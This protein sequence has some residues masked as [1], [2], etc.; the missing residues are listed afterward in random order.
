MHKQLCRIQTQHVLYLY[1][2][3]LF[4]HGK[5][6]STLGKKSSGWLLMPYS[7]KSKYDLSLDVPL[8]VELKHNFI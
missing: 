3:T 6:N 8:S 2:C 1:K 5:V 7:I 4:Y